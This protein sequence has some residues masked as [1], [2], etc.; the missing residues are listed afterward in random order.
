MSDNLSGE[1]TIIRQSGVF[2]SSWYLS[3]HRDIVANG[4]DGIAHFCQTGWRAGARPNPY[5]DPSWYLNRYAELGPAG[6]N[7][8]VHY[9][10]FGDAEGRSP[11]P[12]FDPV[13]YRATY[14][15][16]AQDL[17]LRHFLERRF[18]GQVS[19]VP[20]FDAAYYLENN[21]DV[22][23]GGADP[24]E[25]FLTFGAAE[26]RNPSAE[27][28]VT[29]YRNRYRAMLG[30]E[31]PLLHYLANRESGM[32]LPARPDHEGQ[33]PSAMRRATRPS[34]HFEAF[35][36]V[37]AHAKQA[38]KA[39]GLLSAAIPPCPGKRRMVGQGIY[40]LDESWPG[41]AAFRRPFAAAH[42]SRS[43]VLFPR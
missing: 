33:V 12:W 8:L 36:P 34:A 42:P 39:A 3:Q 38:G 13:W 23:A 29:F 14:G 11:C 21:P 5:F 32:F 28:D 2:L 37:P 15:L 40:R 17:C 19:P 20:V 16:G 10:A 9:I 6:V 41:D 24:F 35:R 22:A 31:N 27:F 4:E 18:T 26:A 43:R 7:P 1:I 25:H 30:D